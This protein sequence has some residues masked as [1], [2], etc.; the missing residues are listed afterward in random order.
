MKIASFYNKLSIKYKFLMPVTPIL[1]ISYSIILGYV[2]YTFQTDTK[3]ALQNQIQK[4]YVIRLTI[5]I[6]TFTN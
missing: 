6:T 3:K 1:L 4:T 2:V 5:S